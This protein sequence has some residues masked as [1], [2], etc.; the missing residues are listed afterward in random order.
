MK[1]GAAKRE[2][3]RQLE[4]GTRWARWAVL[5]AACALVIGVYAWS[6][7]SGFLE[8]MGSGAQDSYYNLLVRG[9]RDGQLNVK[10]EAP[11]G[12]AQ[13]GGSAVRLGWTAS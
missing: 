6:A 9:F 7:H 10:R 13:P 4:A 11:P 3:W 5:G 2:E 8:L 1:R 12:L